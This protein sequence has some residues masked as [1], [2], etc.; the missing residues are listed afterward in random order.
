MRG[1]VKKRKDGRYEGRVDLG[2]DAAGKRLRKSVY[3]NSRQEC[4]VLVNEIVYKTETSSYADPGKLTVGGYLTSWYE[5][6]HSGKIEATT[7]EGYENILYNHLAPYFNSAKLKSLLPLHIEEYY[8][9]KRRDGL[10]DNTLKRHHALLSKAFN[11]AMKNRIL[12]SNPCS[13]VDKPKPKE[14][15]PAVPTREQYFELLEASIGTEF[16]AAILLMGMCGCRRG[17]ALGAKG[18]DFDYA[19]ITY[20]IRREVVEVKKDAVNKSKYRVLGEIVDTSPKSKKVLLV[21][22]YPKGGRSR[23]SGVP[24]W[25]FDYVRRLDQHAYIIGQKNRPEVPTNYFKR[26]ETFLRKAG[27]GHFN[28]HAFRH[29]YGT[30]LME[31]GIALRVAQKMLGHAS[32]QTTEKYQHPKKDTTALYMLEKYLSEGQNPAH[33]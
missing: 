29:F 4:Q 12:T 6:V 13:L 27:L 2:Y 5:S 25:V 32:I 18:V 28:F 11:D 7:R 15:V 24:V 23:E 22:P 30:S 10:S 3:A 17:E 33:K 21:K 8:N 26:Y 16:E 31:A 20:D 1:T 9:A 19:S 14:Y